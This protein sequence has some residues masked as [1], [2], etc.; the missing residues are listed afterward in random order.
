MSHA[1]IRTDLMSGTNVNAYL[2]SFKYMGAGE[3]ATDIDNGCVVKLD[4]I[5]ADGQ[6]AVKDR[7]IWKA[8]TP[9]ATDTKADVVIVAT[10]E[11]MYDERLGKLTDFYNEAGRPA[12]G[13]VPHSND[14]FSVTADALDGVP[15]VGQGVAIQADVKLKVGTFDADTSFGKVIAIETADNLTYYVIEVV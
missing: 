15:T 8:V 10:P 6:G 1:V 13:Y 3:T 5:M 11:V 12:R 9:A 2:R 4:S 7:E 14:I